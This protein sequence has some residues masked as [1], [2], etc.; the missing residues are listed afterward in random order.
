MREEAAW[1]GHVP[2][3]TNR[4]PAGHPTTDLGDHRPWHIAQLKDAGRLAEEKHSALLRIIP[5]SGFYAKVLRGLISDW[6]GNRPFDRFITILFIDEDV[7]GLS[8]PQKSWCEAVFRG[9]R[10]QPIEELGQPENKVHELF[11]EFAAGFASSWPAFLKQRR[12][13]R[14]KPIPKWL[15]EIRAEERKA[16]RREKPGAKTPSQRS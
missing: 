9:Y 5:S 3:L 8:I 1:W 11:D 7:D 15:L 16:K 10:F 14:W 2:I 13:K 6:P 4:L 12:R